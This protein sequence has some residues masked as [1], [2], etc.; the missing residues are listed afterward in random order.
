MRDV[1]TKPRDE[2]LVLVALAAR[3]TVG[4]G[5]IAGRPSATAITVRPAAAVGAQEPTA[6]TGS[7]GPLA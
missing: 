2:R 4:A 3:C 1:Q 6:V 7:R 5:S